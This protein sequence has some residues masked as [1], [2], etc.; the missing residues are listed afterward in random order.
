[1][2]VECVNSAIVAHCNAVISETGQSLLLFTN[3]KSHTPF[4]LEPKLLTLNNSERSYQR[5]KSWQVPTCYS[6][7]RSVSQSV[8]TQLVS[9]LI[10][11][12]V[13]QCNS[14][15]ISLPAST[16]ACSQYRCP[17]RPWFES[18]SP[19]HSTSSQITLV[20]CLLSN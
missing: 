3:R 8:M 1:M 16:I 18:H 20:T 7:R 11:S 2:T 19:Y 17:S 10:L 9:S 14:V 12:H 5:I 15:L 13:D 6:L 4:R